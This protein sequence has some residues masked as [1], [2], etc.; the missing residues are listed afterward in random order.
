MNSVGAVLFDLDGTLAD[1]APDLAHALNET[2]RAHGRAPLPYEVIRPHVSHGGAALIRL[3]FGIT[4]EQEGFEARR[5]HLLRI[6]QQNICRRT[7]LFPGMAEVL[8]ILARHRI[9]WGIV[10]N[11]PGWLTE[12]L[13][14]RLSLPAPPGCVVSGDT[15]PERKPHPMPLLHAA[16]RLG[17]DPR[18]CL[19]VGDAERD[20]VAGR[21]AGMATV[22]ALFGYLAAEDNPTD[23]PVDHLIETPEALLGL[24][25]IEAVHS[26]ARC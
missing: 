7:R 19:Y 8:E 11:K 1:T 24:L 2:L 21:A 17:V 5:R 25:S 18:H 4:P 12:P 23:W 10:T 26:G 20:M 16:R 13:I 9:P 3:G 14:R 22:C 15:C 6:Y